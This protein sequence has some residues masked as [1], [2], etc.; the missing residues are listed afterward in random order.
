MLSNNYREAREAVDAPQAGVLIAAIE[1]TS[2]KSECA[3]R[4]TH[5]YATIEVVNPGK[6]GYT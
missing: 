4:I 1:D 6:H 5:K 2:D 3:A